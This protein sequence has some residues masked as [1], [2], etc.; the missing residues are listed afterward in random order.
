MA[1]IFTSNQV[2]HVYV[3]NSLSLDSDE[4]PVKPTKN[5]AKGTT[6]VGYNSE[7]KAI[8]FM[9]RGAA[10]LVR[11]DLID[12]DKIM[13]ISYTP[14]VK[15]ARKKNAALITLN[16]AAMDSGNV[17][18]GED[19]ILRIVFQNPIGMSPD[20]E[21]WK[22]GVVHAV[23]NMSSSAFY[24]KMAK[25]LAI[26]FSREATKLLD[27]YLTTSGGDVEVNSD[28]NQALT[29]TYTGI[30]LVEAAQDWILGVKQ[31]KPLKFKINN[32]TI[33]GSMGTEVVWS[34]V[35]YSDGRK[36][37]GGEEATES[38]VTTGIPNGGTVTNGHLAAELEYF[39]MGERADL[40]RSIGWPDVRITEYLVDPSKEYDMIG[41]H[42]YYS[43][44]NHAV[45]KSEKDIT[46]LMPR[47]SSDSTPSVLGGIA[48]SVRTA[49]EG[50]VNPS[51]GRDAA[52]AGTAG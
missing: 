39:S 41:I 46:L 24:A 22:Q 37:T 17:F 44:S 45:Q 25:S 40:Y 16:A 36:I 23:S 32:S 6:Y 13:R 12:I 30:K 19:Y 2:N 4:Q 27:I 10:G 34:D 33:N 43:G 7:D 14:A 21:Y 5:S 31:D 38:I 20:H 52:T 48:Q 18:S 11:S 1:Q 42:Y 8:Y 15:M 51:T 35:V 28:K 47:T 9:Q 3:V 49:I 50:F 29:G 26:N